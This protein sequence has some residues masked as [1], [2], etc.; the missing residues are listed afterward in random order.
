LDFHRPIGVSRNILE[1]R[2]DDGAHP[3]GVRGRNLPFLTCFSKKVSK[4]AAVVGVESVP[5]RN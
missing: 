4:D 2:I 3:D 1:G 5:T